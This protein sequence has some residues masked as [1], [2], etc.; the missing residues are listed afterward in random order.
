MTSVGHSTIHDIPLDAW[1]NIMLFI[2]D[3]SL[4]NTFDV[5]YESGAINV[6]DSERLNTFWI[7]LSLV[8]FYKKEENLKHITEIFE[9]PF[10]HANHTLTFDTLCDMGFDK[11]RAQ[12]LIRQGDGTIESVFDVLG[13][14]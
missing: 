1:A 4:T 11:E 10:E 3:Q 8:Q 13:W 2:S 14:S 5:L 9:S 7:L 6:R 12:A